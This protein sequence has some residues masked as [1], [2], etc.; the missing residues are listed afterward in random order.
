MINGFVAVPAAGS[1]NLE[2]IHL[3]KKTGGSLRDS[4]LD[5]GFI[6][7]KKIVSGAALSICVLVLVL[8]QHEAS[9]VRTTAAC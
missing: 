5:E 1:G 6:L 8:Y 7:D 4:F 9:A 2:A 3:I